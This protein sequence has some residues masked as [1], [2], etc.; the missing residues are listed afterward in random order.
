[1]LYDTRYKCQLREIPGKIYC[2]YCL[3][4]YNAY[5]LQCI[6]MQARWFID[7]ALRLMMCHN[8]I[9][10]LTRLHILQVI[11]IESSMVGNR[12]L[13]PAFLH[14]AILILSIILGTFGVMGYLKYG[15]SV[16][17][18]LNTNLPQ[19]STVAMVVNAGICFGILLTFPLQIY[20]VIEIIEKYLFTEGMCAC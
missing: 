12:H 7:Y 1:M 15:N 18:M 19:G 6:F 11:P 5:S 4:F 9:L 13:F 10:Y 16:H 8:A 20:P 3:I 17:Q 14:G 2:F